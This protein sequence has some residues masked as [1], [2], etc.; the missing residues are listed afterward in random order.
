MP[1]NR[2]SF[3]DRESI[4][5]G[6]VQGWSLRKIARGIGCAGSTV[7]REVRRCG[8]RTRYR[9]FAAQQRSKEQRRRPKIRKLVLNREL[10]EAVSVSLKKRWSP[11]Q[12]SQNLR[13][14]RPNDSNWRVSHETIYRTLYVQGRGGLRKELSS[15]LRT[16]RAHRR[17]QGHKYIKGTG[18]ISHMVNISERPAEVEDRAIPGHWEGDLIMGTANKSQIGTLVERQTIYVY[19]DCGELDLYMWRWL[20]PI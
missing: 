3:R 9:A 15:A 17:K 14:Q 7:C 11:Q 2:L 8:G 20:W 4:R 12:V 1:G 13:Q 18:R 19:I 6:L 5:V 10:A 16:G